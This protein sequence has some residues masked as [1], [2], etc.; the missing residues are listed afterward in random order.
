MLKMKKACEKCSAPLGLT[1][2]AFICSYEC[3][4]CHDC[5]TSMNHIC[6]NCEGE[7]VQRPTRVKG[8]A[9]VAAS[10]IKQKLFGK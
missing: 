1:D 7:L 4:F 8:V 5:T 2:R 9:Q 10:Q 6:P 3:T